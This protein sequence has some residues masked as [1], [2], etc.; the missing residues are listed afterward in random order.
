MKGIKLKPSVQSILKFKLRRKAEKQ[1]DRPDPNG[2]DG[3]IEASLER[4]YWPLAFIN[5][6]L[7]TSMAQTQF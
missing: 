5:F 1:K 2:R 3:P 7:M 4:A 6:G